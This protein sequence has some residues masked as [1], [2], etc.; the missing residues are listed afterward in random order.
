MTIGLLADGLLIVLLGAALVSVYRLNRRLAEVRE[1]RAAFEK[2]TADLAAQTKAAA[3]GLAAFRSNAETLGKPLDAGAERGRQVI[4]EV[5]RVSDDLRLLI[6]RA[7]AS[8]T[9]LENA[10]AKARRDEALLGALDEP[11]SGQG[12][13]RG[14]PQGEPVRGQSAPAAEPEVSPEA[15]AFLS[16][17]SG[18]R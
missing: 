9:R 13:T 15:A 17:L 7:D 6:G 5:Q 16:S 3:D 8:S 11:S 14:Q 12:Q 18:M 1:G 2:L 10:V 4:A